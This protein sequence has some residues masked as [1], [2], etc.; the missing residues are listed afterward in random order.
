MKNFKQNIIYNFKDNKI[1]IQF[2]FCPKCQYF[3][4]CYDGGFAHYLSPECIEDFENGK[5]D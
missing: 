2:E 4:D 5:F 1:K 3:K